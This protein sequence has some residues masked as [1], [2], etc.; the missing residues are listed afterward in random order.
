MVPGDSVLE[1]CVDTCAAVVSLPVFVHDAQLEVIG[2]Q[3][4]APLAGVAGET[5][6]YLVPPALFR[7]HNAGNAVETVFLHLTLE[8]NATL[9][10]QAGETRSVPFTHTLPRPAGALAFANATLEARVDGVP[11]GWSG[12]ARTAIRDIEPPSLDAQA[13]APLWAI[14]E[15]LRLAATVRDDG[16]VA[17]VTAAVVGPAGNR[18]VPLSQSGATWSVLLPMDV[19][20]PYTIQFTAADVAGN[21]RSS[22][23][24]GVVVAAVVK[25]VLSVEGGRLDLATTDGTL[26]VHVA[27]VL[28]V[29]SLSVLPLDAK[30]AHWRPLHF[31]LSAGTTQV[32]LATLQDLGPGVHAL[33]LQATNGA[34]AHAELRLNLTVAPPPPSPQGGPTAKPAPG[35]APLGA[36]ILLGAAARR[37]RARSQ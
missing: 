13:L 7:V 17:S 9:V 21:V 28:P 31:P 3:S 4:A 14:G 35:F 37:K 1:A 15:G 6:G 2:P 11:L 24:F 25:P 23:R 22:P 18:T 26:V 19:A 16:A 29:P 32:P 36:L 12:L 34:G 33:L 27:D 8:G 5:V 30:D 10:L 20:G